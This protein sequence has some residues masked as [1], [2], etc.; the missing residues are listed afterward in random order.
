MEI[1]DGVSTVAPTVEVP[2]IAYEH[3][4]YER[5]LSSPDE[6]GDRGGEH[7]VGLLKQPDS[8]VPYPIAFGEAD[9]KGEKK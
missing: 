2:I 1:L 4:R 5:E 6:L 9:K 8:V 7:G 3:P